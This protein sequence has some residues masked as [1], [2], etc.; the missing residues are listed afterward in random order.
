MGPIY[1]FNQVVRPLGQE[2]FVDL[3]LTMKDVPGFAGVYRA[4]TGRREP[5]APIDELAIR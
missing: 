2:A 5:D 3:Y 4:L 1:T